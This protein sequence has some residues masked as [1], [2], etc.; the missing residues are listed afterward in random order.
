MLGVDSFVDFSQDMSGVWLVDTLEEGDG[1][2]SPVEF[3]FDQDVGA[4]SSFDH[5]SLFG[6]GGQLV[7]G[8]VVVNWSHPAAA[9][10]YDVYV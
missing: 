3:T 7:P 6:I 10:A 8:E 1:E 9:F 4:G 2:S 5:A